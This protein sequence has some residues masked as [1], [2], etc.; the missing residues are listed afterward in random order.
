MGQPPDTSASSRPPP[1]SVDPD[2]ATLSER[3]A[4]ELADRWRRGE[5]PRAEEYLD[6]HPGLWHEPEAAADLI[7]EEVCLRQE[8]GEA[9]AAA[10]ALRRFPQW[11]AE[12]ELLLHFHNLIG[13][14]Q[15]P[16]DYPAVGTTVGEFR[17][18]AELGRGARGRVFL[19]SQPSLADRLVVLK[20]TPRD[21]REHLSLSRL[22]HTNIV[23]LHGV[24]EDRRRNFRLLCM[25]YFGGVTLARVLEACAAEPVGGR[26]GRRVLDVLDAAAGPRPALPPSGTMRHYLG[27]A[28]YVRAVCSL[29]ACLA[30]ALQYAHD[31]GLV[32]LDVKPSNVLLAAD[33]QPMLLDFHLAREPIRAD[34]PPEEWVG[35]TLQYM[36][37]E[38]RA[39]VDAI[40]A[41]RRVPVAVD[42]R[43][44]VY[45]LGLVLYEALGGTFPPAGGGP[46][47]LDAC[48]PQV[49]RGL[50]DVVHK[51]LARDSID[52]YAEAGQLAADLRCYLAD[53]PLRGVPNRSLLER[54]RKWRR[55]KPHATRLLA[56]G[57]SVLLAIAAF[58]ILIVA[59]TGQ[60]YDEVRALLADGA[61]LRE[62]GRYDE[63]IERLRAGLDRAREELPVSDDLAKKFGD[64][65]AL[66]RS[67]RVAE[68]VK[69]GVRQR[70]DGQLAKA[71]DLFGRAAQ[72]AAGLPPGAGVV[73]ELRAQ[74][75]L[76]ERLYAAE[77]LHRFTDRTRFLYGTESPDHA[78]V[79]KAAQQARAW[80]E[81]RGG[82][83][84]DSAATLP[85][86]AGRRLA[87]DVRDLAVIWADLQAELDPADR[88][89]AARRALA[90][91]DEV[92]QQ[93]GPSRVIE[94]ERERHAEAAGLTAEAGAA[95]RRGR[96]LEPKTAWEWY[97]LGRSYLRADD[98]GA[99][100]PALRR[101]VEL[102]PDGLWPNFYDG[103][104]AY[105]LGRF[106][107]A[108][109]AF[110][111]CN[112]KTAEC[113]FNR[114]LAYAKLGRPERALAD[115]GRALALAPDWGAAAL[116]R[117]IVYLQARAFDQAEADFDRALR[118]GADPAEVHY[119]RALLHQARG[120]ADAT[121]RS[122]DQALR[123]NP[124]H[125]SA[126]K[127]RVRLG[128]T[129]H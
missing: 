68:L 2:V 24:Q 106:D 27:R 119:H 8:A 48:N 37:P 90:M 63:A 88:A 32:H 78:Q 41:G 121:L 76:A 116:N 6:R 61:H 57:A 1:G 96:Q 3:L 28:S 120:D 103:V 79:T 7:Y 98:P 128:K 117:G 64:E 108:A 5:R 58:L 62:Q 129:T 30:D 51:C 65:L 107:D 72:V 22:Q 56:M 49:S 60:R 17:L 50:A 14:A 46:P 127:L 20:L 111:A 40:Q 55:R 95:R 70:E 11:R 25:P 71:I 47:R 83:L 97:A 36:S 43:S 35:G 16:P 126:A 93:F 113:Y 53:L 45:S 85:A 125:P 67:G 73:H 33:G 94:R 52:R 104:C 38:Q 110:T 44:D 23:P 77:Q 82:L 4:A 109:L 100:A 34:A 59:H 99:A 124:R 12:L 21:G 122:L 123:L 75:A 92:E 10:D 9:D 81:R 39:A 101:A 87:D 31:H 86:A 89:A 15:P 102:Q 18:I 29:G 84:D 115:Y 69:Q 54:W 80:W 26:T 19:A 66:A 13:P 112:P 74:T 118:H 91:L 114:A 105:R 42:A